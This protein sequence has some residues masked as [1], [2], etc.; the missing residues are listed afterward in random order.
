MA[1]VG[2]MSEDFMA[3]QIMLQIEIKYR[4]NKERILKSWR[5][6]G[7]KQKLLGQ[8]RQEQDDLRGKAPG[9]R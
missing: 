8:V 9:Q 7:P 5:M 4:K 6:P 2:T 1:A 3:N